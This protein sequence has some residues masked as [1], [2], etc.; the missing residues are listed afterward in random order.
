MRISLILKGDVNGMQF[1]FAGNRKPETGNQEPGTMDR[2]PGTAIPAELPQ[3]ARPSSQ[4]S[5]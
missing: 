3:G 5:R 4:S 1:P 2:E